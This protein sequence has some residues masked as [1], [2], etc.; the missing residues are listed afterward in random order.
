M[1]EKMTK[2]LD[3]FSVSLNKKHFDAA[4]Q[5]KNDAK[6]KGMEEVMM[7]V[8]T[9]DIFKKSFTFPQIAHNDYAVEQFET[10]SIAESN[11]NNDPNNENLYE[12]FVK[13]ADD[14]AN[15]LK[16]RY[17]DQ[18]VDPK[19]DRNTPSQTLNINLEWNPNKWKK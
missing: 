15:N 16:E 17:K 4:V 14:V 2:E 12:T 18:W 13:T 7:Q 9:C 1:S 8:H 5:M 10:L 19:D 3:Q 6:E 11:L